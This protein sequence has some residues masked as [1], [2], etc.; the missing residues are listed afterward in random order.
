MAGHSH[1]KNIMHRK[2]G[3]A[4]KKA[5]AFGKLIREIT[6]SAKTGM[7]D[8][9]HNPRLRAAVKAALTANMPR[10]TVDRAIKRVAA[11]AD[12]DNYEEVR[13][14]GYGPAGVAIIVEA[15]TDNRNR[16]ASDLRSA[17][18]KHGGAMG[19]TGSVSF[20][21]ERGGVITYKPE[22]ASEDA[23]MEAAIEA[24][25]SDVETY[26]G[27]HEVTTSVEDFAAVRDALEERFGPAESAKL[28][29]W[30]N[31]PIDLNE[32]QAQSVLKLVDVL[33]DHDDVQNVYANF[34]VSD[35]IAERLS[36]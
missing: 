21:F 19:E 2:A 25:A 33:D 31:A 20:Q 17:F 6:V 24:G 4:A 13:Y 18:A 7:P 14:E 1:A 12:S 28:E 23:M 36:A 9:A 30:P 8:P 29:W 16:T 32:E 22:A 26:D 11:G 27:M 3:Q 10:D 5:R 34:E 35:A 15:L